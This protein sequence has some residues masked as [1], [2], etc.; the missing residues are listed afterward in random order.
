MNG[1]VPGAPQRG[2]NGAAPGAPQRGMNGAM[3]GNMVNGGAPLRSV[4]G[5]PQGRPVNPAGRQGVS[6]FAGQI[7][8]ASRSALKS[9]IFLLI[10]LLHTVYLA[11]SVASI[12][13]HQLNYSQFARLLSS[14]DLPQQVTGYMQEFVELLGKLDSGAVPV[15]L[16]MRVP[17]LLF[18][19]GLWIIAISAMAAKERMS[20]VGFVFA[21][22]VVIIGMIKNCLIM[23]AGLIVSV[24]LVVGAWA[25]QVQNMI[26]ASVVTIVLMIVLT[27]MV[28]M[29]YF[30]FFGTLTSIR[31][32]A[33]TGES[34]GRVSGYVAVLHILMGLL[35]IVSLLSGIVNAEVAA[36]VGAVGKIGWMVL[37]GLWITGYRKKV[38]QYEK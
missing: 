21:K 26:V 1:A 7:R 14:V 12:F 35:G 32:N 33:D 11:G 4:N 23:L 5:V 6:N 20:G 38:Q 22:I 36:I 15:N 29:Y 16:A 34:Y 19:L 37:F 24:V 2:M 30:S 13:M 31:R 9:P 27:M 25:S 10:A 28:I 18:C 8:E 17:D 3:P